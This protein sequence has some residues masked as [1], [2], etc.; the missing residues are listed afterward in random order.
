MR[1]GYWILVVLCVGT[2]GCGA[3]SQRLPISGSVKD[4]GGSPFEGTI[5]YLPQ[6]GT[7]GPAATTTIKKGTYHFTKENGPFAGA[8][9]AV[10]QRPVTK[11]MNELAHPKHAAL[12]GSGPWRYEVE[13][14]RA[15]LDALNFVLTSNHKP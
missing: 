1:L 9:R 3:P 5:S 7:S 13:L 4:E 14:T 15:R 10:I 2:V 11:D 12:A 6:P 8:H